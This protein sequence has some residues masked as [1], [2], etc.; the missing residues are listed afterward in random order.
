M[1]TAEAEYMALASAA[2]ESVWMERLVSSIITGIDTSKGI[3]IFEDNQSA[4]GMSEHQ[5][6]HGRTKHVDIKYHFIREQVAANRVRLRYCKSCDM[7]ADILTKALCGPQFK[8]LRAR[9]G[10]APEVQLSN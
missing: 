7:I 10:M 1:S 5:S 9:M 4:I 8:K 3:V 2:Q 6:Y